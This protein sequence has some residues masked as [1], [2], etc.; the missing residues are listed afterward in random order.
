MANEFN[1]TATPSQYS[2]SISP[3]KLQGRS[4][5]FAQPLAE[6]VKGGVEFIQEKNKQDVFGKLDE[7]LAALNQEYFDR[8]PEMLAAQQGQLSQELNETAFNQYAMTQNPTFNTGEEIDAQYAYLDGKQAELNTRLEKLQ[9]ARSQ[10]A[11]SSFEYD[12]RAKQITRELVAENPQLTR[13]LIGRLGQNL[14]LSGIEERIKFDEAMRKEQAASIARQQKDIDNEADKR[15]I[16]RIFASDGTV[17]YD[18]M[19]RAID[20]NRAN[21]GAFDLLQMQ[22]QSGEILQK[23]Q[24]KQLVSRGVHYG[25]VNG[26]YD[27]VEAQLVALYNDNSVPYA[28]KPKLAQT[29][30]SNAQAQTRTLLSPYMGET[31]V[32]DAVTFFDG[33]LESLRKALDGFASGEDAKRYFANTRQTMEDQENIALMKKFNVTQYKF[34]T[35]MVQNLG[36]ADLL[37]YEDGQRFYKDTVGLVSNILRNSTPLPSNYTRDEKSGESNFGL[38]FKNYFTEANK[39][40]TEHAADF[41]KAV[42]NFYSG[43][44][45]P[46]VTGNRDE[47]FKRSEEFINM[48]RDPMNA[49]GIAQ[50]DAN[51]KGLILDN[52]D[53]YNKMLASGFA[54]AIRTNP[55]ANI[56]MTVA[57]DGSLLVRGA[58]QDFNT[59]IINRINAGL[60]A[61]ASV[62]GMSKQEAAKEFYQTYYGD[63]FTNPEAPNKDLVEKN[64]PA[65]LAT[66]D[67]KTLRQF[68]SIDEGVRFSLNYVT[69]LYN[70]QNK[71]T[72]K[73]IVGAM[74]PKESLGP[75][76]TQADLVTSL[77]K[78]TGFGPTERL[79]LSDKVNLSK[80]MSGIYSMNGMNI[81]FQKVYDMAWPSDAKKPGSRDEITK[82][83]ADTWDKITRDKTLTK[84]QKGEKASKLW[85]DLKRQLSLFD[86]T[87]TSDTNMGQ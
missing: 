29:I 13:E 39:G 75:G 41:N 8:N 67:G 45:S 27:T 1:P 30:I 83:A 31:E 40:T 76:A 10:G 64:N 35:G 87:A 82:A 74:F 44:N 11:L 61:Y 48:L 23:E 9:A 2:A 57:G 17:D 54:T 5:A 33:R 68:A 65:G 58:S 21:K 22:S 18:A 81:S 14:G 53:T 78:T 38:L 25:A 84:E 77:A 16:P 55:S 20:R 12:Q 7:R 4:M 26:A 51:S 69:D 34:V 59:R 36:P 73:D 80:L 6:A 71:R 43:I 32:K 66:T 37:R 50:L 46:E 24:V 72:L 85:S 15:N 47:F 63:A 52:I 62:N 86:D 28:N 3:L 56:Q 19:A 42:S 70:K 60:E 49:K 79:D